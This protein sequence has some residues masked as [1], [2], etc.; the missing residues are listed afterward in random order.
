MYGVDNQWQSDL[1]DMSHLSKFNQGYNYILTTIDIFSKYAWAVPLKNKTGQAL[2]EAYRQIFSLGRVPQKLQ[3]D[4][5]TEFINRGVQALLKEYDVK[6]F[7]T[8]NET[9]ASVVERFNRTLKT[10]MWKYFTSQNTHRYI[11][12]LPDLMEAYNNSFHRSIKTKPS[13][14]SRENESN[15]MGNFV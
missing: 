9:K 1:V 8:N 4:K 14:V 12:I 3:T 13:Q 6:F 2:V 10:K 5:G 7:T 11:D 15:G